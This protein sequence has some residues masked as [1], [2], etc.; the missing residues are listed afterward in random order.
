M[1]FTDCV[2]GKIT[3]CLSITILCWCDAVLILRNVINLKFFS[4]FIHL[5]VCSYVYYDMLQRNK[6][7]CLTVIYRNILYHNPC[8]VIHMPV[9]RPDLHSFI[10]L[11]IVN[12]KVHRPVILFHDLITFCPF[13]SLMKGLLSLRGHWHPRVQGQGWVLPLFHCLCPL[14][15]FLSWWSLNFHQPSI[16]IIGMHLIRLL[17]IHQEPQNVTW[18]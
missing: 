15:C 11:Q 13:L 1:F 3:I 12:V 16:I 17:S 18:N 6:S 9:H 7:P 2:R 8:I 4:D 10:I 14:Q 5:V